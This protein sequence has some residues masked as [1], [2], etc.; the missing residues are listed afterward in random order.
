MKWIAAISLLPTICMAQISLDL[1]LGQANIK[2]NTLT[3]N[4]FQVGYFKQDI[5]KIGPGSFGFGGGYRLTSYQA[6]EY[7]PSSRNEVI[8]DVD[9]MSHN[10]FGQVHYKM[11]KYIFGFNLDLLGTSSGSDASTETSQDLAVVENNSFRGGKSD[12]G[13]L[14]SQ[15][16]AQYDFE[17][18]YLR[19]GLAHIVIEYDN[20]G[21]SNDDKRQRFFDSWFMA[22]GKS[23]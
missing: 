4:M 21:L 15:L 5:Y 23:F 19:G 10:L 16:F 3:T 7:H 14:N 18:F 12:T 8:E 9:F 22:V 6:S 13:S 20:I 11:D 2:G 17:D 1:G